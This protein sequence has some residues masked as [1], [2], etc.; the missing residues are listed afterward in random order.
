MQFSEEVELLLEEM[1]RVCQFLQW[2]ESW[3]LAKAE[4]KVAESTIQD[5]G[6]WAYALRQA[7]LR[8]ALH[9]HFSYMWLYVPAYIN[10]S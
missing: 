4:Q 3:W 2:Q 10:C 7:T 6:L 5:E 8:V 9:N 1:R